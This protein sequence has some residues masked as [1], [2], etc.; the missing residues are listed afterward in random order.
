MKENDNI[1]TLKETEELCRLYM[2]CQL[3]VLEEKELQFILGKMDYSSP[4][5]EEAREAMIAEGLLS[6][7]DVAPAIPSDNIPVRIHR[8]KWVLRLGGIAASLGLLVTTALSFHNHSADESGYSAGGS[9]VV[10]YAGGKRL[11]E[12]ESEKAVS[13]AMQK[14]DELIAMAEAKEREAEEMQQYFERLR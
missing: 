8:R 3:S 1:L 14:A 9:V 7:I 2:D 10:A 13:E 6:Q 11:S 4:I 5:I 12:S